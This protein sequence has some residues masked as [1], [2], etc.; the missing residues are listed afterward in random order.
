VQNSVRAIQSFYYLKTMLF[1]IIDG[2]KKTIEQHD[3][4]LDEDKIKI[5][6]G[7]PSIDSDEINAQNDFLYFDESCFIR[8][9][10]NVGRFQYKNLA[11]ISGIG[12]VARRN[13]TDLMSASLT[14]ETLTSSIRFSE[15]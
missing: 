15:T 3:S 10:T 1:F 5:I 8:Q 11:P 13:G 12:V 14:L 6:I 7:H 9:T 2:H 4:V